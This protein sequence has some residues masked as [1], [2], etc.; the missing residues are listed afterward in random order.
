M[1]H[2][3]DAASHADEPCPPHPR[4]PPAWLVALGPRFDARAYS[5][6]QRLREDA[7]I[8]TSPKL[9]TAAAAHNNM[10]IAT[11]R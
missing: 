7:H 4:G 3:C 9:T 6:I 1:Y 11:K 10:V 2:D 5:L 8:A